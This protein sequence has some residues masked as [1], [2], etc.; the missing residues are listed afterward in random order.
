MLDQLDAGALI[1]TLKGSA[2]DQVSNVR[3]GLCV[4]DGGLNEGGKLAPFQTS[5]AVVACTVLGS[6]T[7]FELKVLGLEDG[8]IK[9]PPPTDVLI[10]ILELPFRTLVALLVAVTVE[11]ETIGAL[12]DGAA[13]VV[14][15]FEALETGRRSPFDAALALNKS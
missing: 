2:L 5:S 12:V 7:W 11:R 13:A 4:D 14:A 10:L 1:L 3:A 8:A 6:V 15:I 9:L